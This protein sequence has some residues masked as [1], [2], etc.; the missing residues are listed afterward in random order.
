MEWQVEEIRR[1]L[2]V[3]AEM[4]DAQRCDAVHELEEWKRGEP[5]RIEAHVEAR[6]EP[7]FA[8]LAT[9]AD[10]KCVVAAVDQEMQVRVRRPDLEKCL[11]QVGTA[12]SKTVFGEVMAK[13]EAA[14]VSLEE[15]MTKDTGEDPRE[16]NA[17]G[18]EAAAKEKR[19][20]FEIEEE[21]LAGAFV[22]IHGLKS[23]EDLNDSLGYVKGHCPETGRL[24]VET[25]DGENVKI[26]RDN[27]SETS[28]P[29]FVTCPL[30]RMGSK[31]LLYENCPFCDATA[32][33]RIQAAEQ[34][35]GLP[36]F[37]HYRE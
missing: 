4:Q 32:R 28:S 23:R 30:C 26:R 6:I 29:H 10:L 31:S 20:R 33:E 22:L 37:W 15:Q 34:S 25:E 24:Q 5:A 11:L 12:I 16:H 18:E 19:V 1:E 2:H 14:G 13:V 3:V 21:D 7:R 17:T 35:G 27:V 36:A 8:G 9:A